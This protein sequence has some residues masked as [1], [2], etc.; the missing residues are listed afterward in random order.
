L[1]NYSPDTGGSPTPCRLPG[2]DSGGTPT[3][4]AATPLPLR[5][6]PPAVVGVGPRKKRPL[7]VRKATMGPLR[8][9]PASSPP[10]CARG[11]VWRRPCKF[12]V[13]PPGSGSSGAGSA[14]CGSRRDAAAVL[15]GGRSLGHRPPHRWPRCPSRPP[16]VSLLSPC[17]VVVVR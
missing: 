3:I 16:P 13:L 11:G 15:G 5:R 4:T 14:R 1:A 12:G 2:G 9:P 6:P 7:P 17:S 8:S 10:L